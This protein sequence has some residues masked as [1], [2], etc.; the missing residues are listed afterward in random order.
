MGYQLLL[1][2]PETIFT[3]S[4]SPKNL[5]TRLGIPLTLF[6][7]LHTLLHLGTNLMYHLLSFGMLRAYLCIYKRNLSHWCFYSFTS[8]SDVNVVGN[9]IWSLFI[10]S[11]HIVS[12]S[13]YKKDLRM[14]IW[15]MHCNVN[16]KRILVD[17]SS[18]EK[19]QCS[20]KTIS[21]KCKDNRIIFFFR[22]R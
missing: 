10:L 20:R 12:Y 14:F 8:P 15:K 4:M 16:W 17:L 9:N 3:D 7:A 19:D 5:L 6:V 1:W 13:T 18:T 22:M 11:Y 21:K 2:F